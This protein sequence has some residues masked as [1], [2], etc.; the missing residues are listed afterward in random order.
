MYG[1]ASPCLFLVFSNAGPGG[2]EALAR[3]YMEVHGPDAFR[4]GTFSALH[5]YEAVGD[6]DARFLAVWEGAFPSLDAARAR[7]AP[8]GGP[9]PDR[10]R[11]TDDLVV[12][13]SALK[14]HTGRAAP[15]VPATVRTLTLVE[16]G[17]FD[18]PGVATYR[19]GDL[20]LHESAAEPA[21]AVASW[22]SSGEEGMAPHGP[23]RTIFEDPEA[24]PPPGQGLDSPWISHWR[25]VASLRRE[26]MEER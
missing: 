25:P 2:D 21:E 9:R 14:F 13:W 17:S 5:R 6:Y 11:I 24:W 15:C 18:P 20:E 7:M 8:P 3:W 10:S 16:G 4:S 26:D 23:Y 22:R 19:Y 12:V 1:E